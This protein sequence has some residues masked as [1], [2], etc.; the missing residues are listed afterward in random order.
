MIYL[1][2]DGLTHR[3]DDELY[4]YK[5]YKR[6]KLP[7]GKWRYYYDAEEL[8]K[9][10]RDFVGPEDQDKE[11]NALKS[12]V[13]SLG[14]AKVLFNNDAKSLKKYEDNVRKA[15]KQFV[16]KRL[17]DVEKHKNI[18]EYRYKKMADKAKKSKD[19]ETQKM[20]EESLK[21]TYR[22]KPKKP[23]RWTEY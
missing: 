18:G 17:K 16:D 5:Y 14:T 15:L 19:K 13:R 6:V 12:A 20:L 8:L 7:N 4:H 10:A 23:G 1:G 2:K 22:T 11:G 21:E 3:I 9:S